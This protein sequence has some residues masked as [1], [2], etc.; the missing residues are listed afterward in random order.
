MFTAINGMEFYIKKPKNNKR[1]T[2]TIKEI[3]II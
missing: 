1:S 3:K 2:T